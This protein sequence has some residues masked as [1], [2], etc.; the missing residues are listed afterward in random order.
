[1]KAAVSSASTWIFMSRYVDN[2]PAEMTWSVSGN[3]ALSVDHHGPLATIGVPDAEWSGME[4]LTFRATD[5]GELSTED[6]A[7]FTGHPQ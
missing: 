2:S 4:T 5:P 1:M 7:V 6:A 3:S